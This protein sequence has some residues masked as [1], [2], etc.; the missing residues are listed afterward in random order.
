MDLKLVQLIA[1]THW[2]TTLVY[3]GDRTKPYDFAWMR[4]PG[5]MAAIA[6]YADGIGPWLGMIVD[7][8]S[9][10][11]HLQFAGMVAEAHAA[12]LVVHPYT[13]R[14]E[15]AFIPPYADDFEDLLT[16]FF[17]QAGVD[18]VFTDFPDRAVKVRQ[19]RGQR[20]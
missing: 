8:I 5:S 3:E 18:G 11:G 10:R 15:Q 6:A 7:A 1:E 14:A 16:I 4:T 12:G 17:F 2:E 20:P 13:F 19:D 9:T